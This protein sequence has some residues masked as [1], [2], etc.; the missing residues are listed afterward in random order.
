MTAG[1]ISLPQPRRP[2]GEALAENFGADDGPFVVT[3]SLPNAEI[4]VT[5]INVLRPFGEMSAPLPR[6]DGYMIVYHVEDL[7]GIQYREDGRPFTPG[8]VRAGGTTIHDLRREPVVLVDRPLH[9]IQWFM[10]H[11]ALDALADAGNAPYVDDLRHEPTV[12]VYD[13]VIGHMNLA[14]L[15]ALRAAGRVSRL[16]VDSMTTAFAAH[17]AEAYGGMRAARRRSRGLLASWQER[18]AKEMMLADLTG[19]TSLASIAAACGLSGAHF[20]R[21][22]RNSTGLPPHAWLNQARVERAM[23]LLRQRG[24]S[25]SEIALECGFFDQSH[26]TRVFA[27]R[28]GL[29]PGAWRRTVSS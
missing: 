13:D 4:A 10:P 8:H 28:V 14:L 1:S 5:E 26:F 19:A 3:R 2:Y 6:Q 29:A 23:T 16:F 24:K 20:A 7:M 25:L 27:R 21:A 17:L 9:T 15:P 18:Q 12:P 11:A 22:F